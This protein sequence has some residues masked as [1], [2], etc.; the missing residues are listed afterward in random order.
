MPEIAKNRPGPQSSKKNKVSILRSSA[1]E[2]PT[3]VASIDEVQVE[4]VLPIRTSGLPRRYWGLS[5][6]VKTYTVNY[7]QKKVF[8]TAS[9]K[10]VQL[11]EIFE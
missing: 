1:A 5:M 10:K 3:F 2:Y 11:F 9:W 7:H 8:S 4:A 6:N